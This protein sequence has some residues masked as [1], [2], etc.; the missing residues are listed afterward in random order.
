VRPF[1][2]EIIGGL[3]VAL[4]YLFLSDFLATLNRE[5]RWTLRVHDWTIGWKSSLLARFRAL[6]NC[7]SAIAVLVANLRR[8]ARLVRTRFVRYGARARAV[9]GRVM[10]PH[11]APSGGSEFKPAQ[12]RALQTLESEPGTSITRSQYERLGSVGRSQSAQDLSE[13]V[14]AGLLVRIGRGRTTRYVLAHEP[15]AQR[16]WS[17]DRI[18]RELET[19][20]ADRSTWPTPGEFKAAGHG[21]LYVAASRYGGVRYWTKALGLERVDRSRKATTTARAPLQSRLTWAFAGGLA[22]VILAGASATAVLVTH[23][24]ESSGT[25]GAGA[26]SASLSSD[27]ADLKPFV[28]LRLGAAD[29][30]EAAHRPRIR[31]HATTPATR[32]TSNV[33]SHSTERMTLV[34]NTVPAASVSTTAE[35]S[36]TVSTASTASTASHSTGPGPLR[37]PPSAPAPS[38][39]KAP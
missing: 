25:T 34:S 24:F 8:Q 10:V 19:F 6:P 39:L 12:Q 7:N 11:R 26:A 37:A 29:Q 36:A 18:R 23:P 2:P 3:V 38:P 4:W 31:A 15:A 22:G 9:G 28:P 16:R 17:P 32:Q 14:A 35:T 20:C 21:D 1:Y 27:R 5:L 13:L 30:S 33:Q